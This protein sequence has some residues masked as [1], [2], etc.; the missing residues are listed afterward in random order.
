MASYVPFDWQ[1]LGAVLTFVSSVSSLAADTFF[2]KGKKKTKLPAGPPGYPLIGNLTSLGASPHLKLTEWRRDYGDI[3]R[4]RMGLQD[5]VVINGYDAI[6]EALVKKGDRLSDR[7]YMYVL[8]ELSCG[9]KG[10]GFASYNDEYKN[11]RKAMVSILRR[12]GMGKG[13]MEE[14]IHEEVL[15]LK[16]NFAEHAA[17]GE[18]FDPSPLLGCSVLNV[19]CSMILGARFEQ[20]DPLFHR[21]VAL[22]DRTVAAMGPSQILN[23]FPWLRFVPGLGQTGSDVIGCAEEI[24]EFLSGVIREQRS[25]LNNN[26]DV[27]FVQ[28][29]EA[30][31]K[32]DDQVTMIMQDLFIGGAETTTTTLRWALL[33]LALHPEVQENMQTE[34]DREVGRERRPSLTDK[35]R[36]PYTEAA[37][38]E[39]QR[40]RT[41]APLSI[42]HAASQDVELR[43]YHIPAGTQVLV[44]LWSVHMDP[45]HWTD[46][47]RFDPTRFLNEQGKVIRPEQFL[48]FSIGRRQ[49]PGEQLA[50]T[51]LFLFLTT[52]LQHFTFELPGGAPPSTEGVMG[53]SLSPS[54]YK[55]RVRPRE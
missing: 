8:H 53:I 50:K 49:C 41:I 32:D 19:I 25:Q 20:D 27:S 3:Y 2:G 21:L 43:G 10:I 14:Q 39:I 7:P 34:L 52:L 9:G 22:M 5:A 26:D 16:K 37:I 48:P 23:V 51:E 47:D 40:V 15:E 6:R 28:S 55:I 44:N 35:P 29:L 33:Y 31:L 54:S 11:R 42:P 46:P 45:A 13:F 18:A 36:L 24:R 1:G 4:I 38:L 17:S 30:A 12:F